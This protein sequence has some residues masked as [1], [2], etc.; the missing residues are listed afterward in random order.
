MPVSIKS[1]IACGC[2][3]AIALCMAACGPK[4]IPPMTVSDLMED[5]VALDGVLMKCNQN[6]VKARTDS[7]CQNARIAIDRLASKDA[8]AEEAKRAA[9]FERSREQLRSTQERQRQEQ[10]A[11]TPKVDVYHMPVVP[12]EQA[13]PS[14]DPQ[15]PIVGKVNP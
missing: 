13:P 11:K 1:I 4:R 12:V 5:R 3:T 15:S 10:A 8:P 6:P 2:L 7:D 9:E 14:K